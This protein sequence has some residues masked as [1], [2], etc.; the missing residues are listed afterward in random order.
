MKHASSGKRRNDEDD[1]SERS[2]SRPKRPIRKPR[3]W[4]NRRIH[5]LDLKCHQLDLRFRDIDG[6]V[7]K[8][9]VP[10]SAVN[11]MR[12]QV[13]DL[14]DAGAL[15]PTD[16]KAAAELI[17]DAL[18]S[19][20]E[21]KPLKITR[22]G[23]WRDGS[24]ISR[25]W[26]EGNIDGS[27]RLVGGLEVDPV[28]GLK[29]GNLEAYLDGL[30]EPCEASD[31]LAF[32]LGVAYGAPLLDL[33]GEEEGVIFNLHGDSTAGKSLTG[34]VLQSTFGRAGKRDLA[35]YDISDRG[36]T[37]LCAS[38]NDLAVIL[39]EQGRNKG[40]MQ[41]IRNIAFTVASGRGRI[42][43]E[44]AVRDLGLPNL[45]WR[46]FGMTSGEEPLETHSSQSRAPGE[47]IRHID[48]RIPD[49]KEGG[50][51]NRVTGSS[52]ERMEKATKLA[53]QIEHTIGANYGVALRPY[54]KQ[55][56]AHRGSLK[57]EVNEIVS[58]FV[59]SAGAATEPWER[60]FAEKFGSANAGLMLSARFGCAP[61]EEDR[62]KA[63]IMRMYRL[64]RRSVFST[65]EMADDILL[66]IRRKLD[67]DALF[68]TLEKGD[69]LAPK[70]RKRAWGFRRTHSKHGLIIA[71]DPERFEQMC[72]SGAAAEAVL[73]EL[74]KRKVAVP[75]AGGK[76]RLQI[77]VQGFE[78]DGRSRWVCLRVA[79]L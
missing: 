37:D 74:I 9:Q 36:L 35:T 66:R 60:R 69:S 73:D 18:Q 51:F 43:S 75:G 39:D 14:L 62:A 21:H 57:Q 58:D 3:I 31:F 67:D 28:L 33:L 10:R 16:A 77:A 6:G 5:D 71:I 8:L 12:H 2:T 53:A 50:I 76:R 41:Q 13:D 47:R 32:A 17:K 56:V 23:G 49:R 19:E 4:I 20:P 78:R 70:L 25:G 65:T 15:L 11:A 64:A 27:V 34:R 26:N 63:K 7:S 79:A 59:A 48:M 44:K 29:S 45:T 68:P 55:L 46:V 30:K 61:L 72:G 24:F 42:L 54:I 40:G 1:N 22:R 38:R 52:Q